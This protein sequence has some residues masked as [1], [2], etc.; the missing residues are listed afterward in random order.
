LSNDDKNL[1]PQ[2]SAAAE[3]V[4][5]ETF[6]TCVMKRNIQHAHAY[7]TTQLNDQYL[8]AEC[9]SIANGVQF[10]ACKLLKIICNDAIMTLSVVVA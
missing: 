10:K 6:H 5:T 7:S 1:L 8:E 4:V 9:I 3:G 2:V